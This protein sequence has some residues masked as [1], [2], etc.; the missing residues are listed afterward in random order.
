MT[1]PCYV[2]CADPLDGKIALRVNPK[3]A[4]AEYV[5]IVNTSTSTVDLFGHQ[6]LQNPYYYDFNTG[7]VL[8]PGETLRLFMQSANGTQ[9]RSGV[10]IARYWNL[11]TYQLVDGGDVVALRNYRG[12]DI[13]CLAW[14]TRSC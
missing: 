13:R 3:G 11:P 9:A 2:R 14:G 4:S 10:S 7:D 1:Y 12:H 8:A 5:D 6:L